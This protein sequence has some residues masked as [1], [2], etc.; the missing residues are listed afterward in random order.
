MTSLTALLL[1]ASV[2]L[3]ESTAAVPPPPEQVAADCEAPTYASDALVCADTS[4]L[5]LDTRMRAALAAAGQEIVAESRSLV[6]PQAAWFRRRSLCAFSSRHA[7]CLSAAYADRIAVLRALR[8]SSARRP[9]AARTAACR[10]APGGTGPVS[11]DRDGSGAGTIR[12][13]AGLVLA[14]AS[15]LEPADDWV[16]F[17]RVEFDAHGFRLLT[18]SGTA[19]ACETAPGR[20]SP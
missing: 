19:V 3:A 1:V 14:V 5:A 17:L 15:G 11:V 18:T 2:M 13:P 20:L 6:E 12:D 9:A 7:A 4:L 8:G 10:N 16:P